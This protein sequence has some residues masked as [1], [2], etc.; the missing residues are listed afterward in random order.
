MIFFTRDFKEISSLCKVKIS[1][2]KRDR[3]LY[4]DSIW[5]T[6]RVQQSKNAR[7]RVLKNKDWEKRVVTNLSSSL[8]NTKRN[9]LKI[10]KIMSSLW[11]CNRRKVRWSSGTTQFKDNTN[12]KLPSW[13]CRCCKIKMKFIINNEQHRKMSTVRS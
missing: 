13:K 11:I 8:I 7:T 1:K 3:H 12:L 4:M 9:W 6:T 2:D 10:G 5:T